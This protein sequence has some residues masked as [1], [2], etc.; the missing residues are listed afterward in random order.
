MSNDP[1]NAKVTLTIICISAMVSALT[2]WYLLTADSTEV[3]KLT[4]Q[5]N[6]TKEKIKHRLT[7]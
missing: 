2:F 5:D 3:M 6:V 7:P 1:K 4:E